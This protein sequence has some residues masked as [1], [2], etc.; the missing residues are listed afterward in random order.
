T[1]PRLE[2]FPQCFDSILDS[3]ALVNK[4]L[5]RKKEITQKKPLSLEAPYVRVTQDARRKKAPGL[6]FMASTGP[7]FDS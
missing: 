1:E 7:L 6:P 4:N 5:K 3:P 2:L